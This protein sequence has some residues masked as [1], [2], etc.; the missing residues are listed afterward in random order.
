MTKPLVH[1]VKSRVESIH[2]TLLQINAR[3]A[4]TIEKL[5]NTLNVAATRVAMLEQRLERSDAMLGMLIRRDR[6][7]RGL[8]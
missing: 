8:K 2:L 7:R 4:L 1:T 3:Q 6:E 5:S